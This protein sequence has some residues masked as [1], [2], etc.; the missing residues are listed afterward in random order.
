M[1]GTGGT[2]GPL[3]YSLPHSVT[4]SQSSVLTRFRGEVL[5]KT[6]G[7]VGYFFTTRWVST[8]IRGGRAGTKALYH[9]KVPPA[10]SLWSRRNICH[11]RSC[12]GISYSWGRPPVG[13]ASCSG[14]GIL[15]V[16]LNNKRARRLFYRILDLRNDALGNLNRGSLPPNGSTPRPALPFRDSSAMYFSVSQRYVGF[17]HCLKSSADL[18]GNGREHVKG[19]DDSD[20]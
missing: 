10:V 17:L 4:M 14:T 11:A 6:P 18:Y 20:L 7:G 13:R 5:G 2:Q 16:I 12:H 1:S 8:S 19:A 15:P 9:Q 3:C